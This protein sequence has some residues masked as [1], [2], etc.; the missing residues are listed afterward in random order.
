MPCCKNGDIMLA[1]GHPLIWC[2][3]YCNLQLSI[4][5]ECWRC[6]WG[7]KLLIQQCIQ[8]L[9]I[10][11]GITQFEFFYI[12]P[13]K[14]HLNLR[15]FQPVGQCYSLD[16]LLLSYPVDQ[17][18]IQYEGMKQRTHVKVSAH[19]WCNIQLLTTNMPSKQY[20]TPPELNC[21]GFYPSRSWRSYPRASAKCTGAPAPWGSVKPKNSKNIWG[22]KMKN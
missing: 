10:S 12:H 5:F 2:Y 13:S 20:P 6:L 15:T 21:T 14:H 1:L 22:V 3:L 11:Q 19:I 16:P 4:E 7:H 8:S 18:L 17:I 9:S